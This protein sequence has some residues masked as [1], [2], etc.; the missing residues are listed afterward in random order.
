MTIGNL[1]PHNSGSYDTT[2]YPQPPAK[3]KP[4]LQPTQ[5]QAALA[6]LA[7][8]ANTTAEDSLFSKKAIQ[9]SQSTHQGGLLS[10]ATSAAGALFHL[11]TGTVASIVLPSP[12]YYSSKISTLQNSLYDQT[13][14]HVASE[15][16]KFMAKR[17]IH[18]FT[19]HLTHLSADVAQ[20]GSLKKFVTIDGD[21]VTLSHLGQ[22][23]LSLLTNHTSLLEE[24]FEVNILR[25]MDNAI[26]SLH[27][28]KSQNPYFLVE[29]VQESLQQILSETHK[30]TATDSIS[31]TEEEH[32]LFMNKLQQN[33]MRTIFPNN[34]ADIEIPRNLQGWL[35][36]N[37]FLQ[38]QEKALPRK[39]NKLFDSATSEMA[40]Y[41]ILAMV[42][43][44]F[45]ALLATETT[46]ATA[47]EKPL[48]PK[49]EITY[50][51]QE[52]FNQT[53]VDATSTFIHHI[54]SKL[55]RT[56]KPQFLKQIQ[57]QGP[58]LVQKLVNLNLN[59]LLNSSMRSA[60]KRLSPEGS[61]GQKDGKEVFH[62]VPKPPKTPAQKEAHHKKTLEQSKRT[63]NDEITT[64]ATDLNGLI[65]R[66]VKET[67]KNSES[68]TRLE[69]IK[70][71]LH[72]LFRT[73]K[74][75]L[76]R[77]AFKVFRAD[78]QISKLSKKVLKIAD[79]LDLKRAAKPL[80]KAILKK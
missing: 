21:N 30:T 43:K 32:A 2:S 16:A 62:F 17:Q 33:I 78:K 26:R 77:A 12:G 53:L 38:I 48:D 69:K 28:M 13:G 37:T 29:L 79:E 10:Y 46:T 14:A 27:A 41:K 39:M 57:K 72:S 36:K 68:R 9:V 24:T 20:I 15:T 61:W 31:T 18:K 4:T 22:E 34:E 8:T 80:K 58:L 23:F 76:V 19:Y 73:I 25:A 35:S 67:S 7:N 3:P 71:G 55:L 47:K 63:I 11:V 66:L 5:Q 70:D 45:K 54:D 75:G 60:C 56:L 64:I 50:P 44:E 51:Q 49:R 74:K 42:V 59:N 1:P 40:K 6:T 52:Q 65:S